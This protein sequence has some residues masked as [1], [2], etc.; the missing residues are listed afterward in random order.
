MPIDERTTRFG[1]E[2]PAQANTLKNDV[3]RLRDAMNVLDQKAAMLDDNGKVKTEQLQDVVPL[4]D[5]NLL[6][7]TDNLPPSVV[8]LDP[9]ETTLTDRQIP[10]HLILATFD[11][12]QE[13]L[14]T[15][16]DAKIG[17]IVTITSSTRMF[18]LKALPAS[19]RDNW[20]ELVQVG[21][22]KVNGQ[23]LLAN[24]FDGDL[25]VAE[26]GVN[27]NITSLTGLSGPLVLGGQGRTGYEAVTYDQLVGAM[28]TS[29]GASM[30]GVMNNFIGAVE[31]FM[32]TRP[33][34]PAGHEPA[35]GQLLKRADYPDMWAAIKSGLIKAV[36][37]SL[38]TASTTGRANFSFGD[39]D[40]NT[41]TT[42]RLP[43]L[44]GIAQPGKDGIPASALKS[45]PGLFLRGDGSVDAGIAGSVR[46]N[47][48]PNIT[49]LVNLH[50]SENSNIIS[51][52]NGA[53]VG[54][55]QHDGKYRSPIGLAEGVDPKTKSFGGFS[56]DAS[57]AHPAYGRI[58]GASTPTTEVRP[59]S[60]SG[61]WLIRV[62]GTFAAANTSF[63]V[64]NSEA[65]VPGAG[66]SVTGGTVNCRYKIANNDVAVA[67]FD[68]DGVIGTASKYFARIKLT[69][70]LSGQTATK[71]FTFG[72]DG[73]L[74]IPN[75]VCYGNSTTNDIQVGTGK[76]GWYSAGSIASAFSIYYPDGNSAPG[77]Y[78][79]NK[80]GSGYQFSLTGTTLEGTDVL[81]SLTPLHVGNSLSSDYSG[82]YANAPF[83]THARNAA[84]G[85][86]Q[87]QPG[88][89]VYGQTEGAG[90]NNAIGFGK[91]TDGG[92]HFGHPCIVGGINDLNPS[93]LSA[94]NLAWVFATSTFKNQ[95]PALNPTQGS[96]MAPNGVI[97]ANASDARIKRDIADYS[98]EQ[99]LAKIDQIRFRTFILKNDETHTVQRGVIA[100]EIEQIDPLYV[101]KS[102]GHS[103]EEEINDFHS[104]NNNILLADA[105]AAIQVLSKRVSELE[106]KLAS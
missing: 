66:T 11:V 4:L 72:S 98:P 5:D 34:F 40:I 24:N 2:L 74:R 13:S 103:G 7:K 92:A 58:E 85:K 83:R 33:N 50:G 88:V 79:R 16:L 51:G 87:Y 41:G 46:Q 94:N 80:D 15:E 96:I 17:D 8:M 67:S 29:G 84:L 52:T 73:A 49:G 82:L 37:D 47:A 6:I 91:Y 60:A 99:S 68:V 101:F 100:Q 81:S 55:N 104:L 93:G 65:G 31:W 27:T 43:D 23:P 26:P 97:T 61:I 35:D 1:L 14:I 106:A 75:L 22:S 28:G 70:T 12:A 39:G 36:P 102:P 38:W 20:K 78:I 89:A 62:S 25:K 59:N 9:G 105:L 57:K 48:S 18:E 56:I 69:T 45:V 10:Q 95:T 86:P 77:I 42:F 63:D 64:I 53:L 76:N 90:Y 71:H 3:N 30:S 21:I 19:N 32:G 54:T 44:N